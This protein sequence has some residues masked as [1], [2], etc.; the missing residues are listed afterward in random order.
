MRTFVLA[1]I[2]IPLCLSTFFNVALSQTVQLERKPPGVVVR[3]AAGGSVSTIR[4]NK[5]ESVIG[6]VGSLDKKF[7]FVATS[8]KGWGMLNVVD[9]EARTNVRR[10]LVKG[11]LH[12]RRVGEERQLVAVGA[13]LCLISETG[14]VASPIPL[15]L[16][17]NAKAGG[18][19][20]GVGRDHIAI[21]LTNATDILYRVAI[22]D[23]KQGRMDGIVQT[24]TGGDKARLGAKHFG[25]DLLKSAAISA[26]TL[27]ST[28][29]NTVYRDYYLLSRPDGRFV[30]AVDY[31]THKVTAI[32]VG[33][34]TQAAVIEL[35]KSISSVK[36]SDDGK[37]LVATGNV[38]Q[39]IDM[40]SNQ[41]K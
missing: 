38:S 9:L 41:I 28:T 22:I 39:R 4:L 34:T 24:R 3:N 37:E 15:N 25:K 13:D 19:V 5:G 32:S 6:S 20:V 30:Y 27:T 35:D 11:I 1:S 26:V 8:V 14:D 17:R 29:V 36:L 23:I 7:V 10:P 31:G 16:G 2:V 12:L 40:A 33:D 18:Q 21:S